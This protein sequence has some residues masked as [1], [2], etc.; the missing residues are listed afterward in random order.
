MELRDFIRQA[1]VEIVGGI[2]DAQKDDEVGS[3]I[4]PSGVGVNSAFPDDSGVK[5]AARLITTVAQFDIAVTAETHEEQT[6]KAGLGIKI[7]DA[8]IQGQTGSK[9]TEASRIKFS[10]PLKL[11]ESTKSW[12]EKEGK[13]TRTLLSDPRDRR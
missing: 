12:A 10:V 7:I 5:H 9:T 11:P 4:V 13:T 8:G 2:S 3:F 1:L 6:G